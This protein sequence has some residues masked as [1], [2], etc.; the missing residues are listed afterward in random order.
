MAKNTKE[1]EKVKEVAGEAEKIESAATIVVDDKKAVEPKKDAVN[2]TVPEKIESA[3]TVTSETPDVP[4]VQVSDT[5]A[6]APEIKID[7]KAMT[8]EYQY[9]GVRYPTNIAFDIPGKRIIIPGNNQSLKGK[10]DA[11]VIDNNDIQYARVLTADWTK[12]I[13]IYGSMRHFKRG[14]FVF[15]GDLASAKA[16]AQE[17]LEVKHGKETVDPKA[18]GVEKADDIGKK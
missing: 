8:G 13:E 18:K 9:I 7:T 5:P 16:E 15:R 10:K 17:M 12:V 2:P 6:E 4:D 3:A 14:L 11:G 1:T